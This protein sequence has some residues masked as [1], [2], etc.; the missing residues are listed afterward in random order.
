[1]LLLPALVCIGLGIAGLAG[2]GLLSAER[3][4]AREGVFGGFGA[5]LA[6]VA[7]VGL[8]V[9]DTLLGLG[10]ILVLGGDDDE[11]ARPAVTRSVPSPDENPTDDA[12]EPEPDRAERPA[13]PGLLVTPLDDRSDDAL[14]GPPVRLDVG[15]PNPDTFPTSYEALDDLASP[16]VLPV[17]LHGAVP[18]TAGVLRQ[19]AASLLELCANPV[20]FL[21]D[22]DG[23]ARVQY[24]VTADFVSLPSGDTCGLEGPPCYLLVEDAG[25]ARLAGI[26]T[27]FGD[28]QPTA[29]RI[30]VEP[31]RGITDGDIVT[32]SVE[33]YPPGARV[34]AMLCTPPAATGAQRCGSPG[35]T[36]PFTVGADGTGTT[37]LRI[38]SGPVG[39][40]RRPCNRAATCGV[41]VAAPDVFVR[42]PVVPISFAAPPGARY[43]G[44]RVAVGVVA[45]VVFL[46][47]T[48][49][50]I[51]RTDW[52]PPREGDGHEIDDARYADL[53]AI[54]ASLPPEEAEEAEENVLV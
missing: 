22:E 5:G 30:R 53:D 2:R 13:A 36:A 14:R 34:F 43:D 19:C 27:I 8:I 3:V 44:Q 33:H 15:A 41:S 1:M 26:Q 9:V 45:A 20:P 52:T 16:T 39:I 31:R 40:E 7:G 24:L 46:A 50:L 37:E 42:A 21:A 38:T 32:V 47:L 54:I 4:S 51:R 11:G 35:P 12:A 10:L 49:W 28:A 18:F 6:I 17:E 48:I 23:R 29:G 25:G